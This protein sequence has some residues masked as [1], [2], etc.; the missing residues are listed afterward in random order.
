[1]AHIP[2][3]SFK[4]ATTLSAYRIVCALSSTADTVAYPEA[5]TRLPIGVTADDADDALTGVPVS[6]PGNIARVY[7]NDTV[8]SG[9]LVAADSSGRGVPFT[10]GGQTTTG[11]T[12]QS[13]YVG[14][15]VGPKV[16]ATGTI[17]DVYIMPGYA[18]GS[19]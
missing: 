5:N 12:I 8:T 4:V 6:G 14:I 15:L 18:R 13:A 11:F 3:V 9:Q 2:P 10:L 1:M 17:A 16:D 7:F 19:S